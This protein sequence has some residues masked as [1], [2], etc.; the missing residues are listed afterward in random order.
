MRL[1]MSQCRLLKNKRE[2]CHAVLVG[3][4]QLLNMGVLTC[5]SLWV[6]ASSLINGSVDGFLVMLPPFA[7]LER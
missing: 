3:Q 6:N 5:G 4:C 1:F 2:C 7:R